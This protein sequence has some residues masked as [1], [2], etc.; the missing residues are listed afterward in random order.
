MYKF[1]GIVNGVLVALMILFN[2]V[3]A[4]NFG[5]NTSL[6]SFYLIGFLIVTFVSIFYSKSFKS[7]RT[8]PLFLY[9]AG[10]LGVLNVY[11]NN[12]T[13][14]KLGAT[15][16]LGLAIYGQL[17]ASVFVDHFGLFGLKKMPLTPK[18]VVGL[19]IMYDVILI[20]IFF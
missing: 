5:M 13:F 12:I 7:F 17:I 3:L 14:I 2:S 20:M 15:L 8:I 9:S 16:T 1:L 18:K 11:L 4:E 6:L 10:I 19:L